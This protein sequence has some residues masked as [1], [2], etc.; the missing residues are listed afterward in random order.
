M[1]SQQLFYH[2][3]IKKLARLKFRD[4]FTKESFAMDLLSR[5]P[6][7][8]VDLRPE[9]WNGIVKCRIQPQSVARALK[10]GMGS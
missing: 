5:V 6:N 8:N 9:T 2:I 3:G 4:N 10:H 1:T 7:P